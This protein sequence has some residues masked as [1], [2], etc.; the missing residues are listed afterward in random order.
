MYCLNRKILFQDIPMHTTTLTFVL[1]AWDRLRF[2]RHPTKARMPA[3]VCII[4][5]W[6]ASVCFV[7]PYPI[8]IIYIDLGVCFS[9]RHY[10]LLLRESFKRIADSAE[11]S[12]SDKI[13][14]SK[15][16]T[17]QDRFT[18]HN[19]GFPKQPGRLRPFQPIQPQQLP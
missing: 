16:G 11:F 6:L 13:R 10:F 4:G 19:D 12:D 3:F 5:T 9:S 17:F 18:L 14:N 2:I 8:Y 15:G 7:L 1:M